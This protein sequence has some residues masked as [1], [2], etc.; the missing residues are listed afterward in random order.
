MEHNVIKCPNCGELITIDATSYNSVVKQIRDAEFER[1]LSERSS[2]IERTKEQEK[3]IL[4]QQLEGK[5]QHDLNELSRKY[6]RQISDNTIAAD[7]RYQEL[8]TNF[9]QKILSLQSENDKNIN[10]ITAEN[11]QNIS[12]KDI[13]VANLKNNIDLI[14]KENEL[15]T[16][17]LRNDFEHALKL[18]DDELAQYKD[19]RMKQ[20]TKMIGE[21]LEVFCR[22]S[23]NQYRATQWPSAYF[24]KD[25]DI[26]TGSKGDFILRDFAE[27]IE[28]LSV[29]IECKNEMSTTATKHKN[30]D[31]FKELDKDR[32]E[33]NCRW[34]LMV[35]TLE[36]DNELYNTGVAY[37]CYEYPDMYVV[38]PQNFIAMLE[39]LRGACIGNVESLK[40]AKMA[41]EKNCDIFAFEKEFQNYIGDIKQ[42]M[43]WE[44]NNIDEAIRNIESM[45]KTLEAAKE[46]LYRAKKRSKA[47]VNKVET[48]TMDKL[49]KNSPELA[50]NYKK[51][52]GGGENDEENK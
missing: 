11:M 48:V 33:K 49:L 4:K 23:F 6:E 43:T 22:N 50:A 16:E 39:I 46:A 18:K 41:E 3:I 24:E 30:S 40:R 13:E 8:R 28:Y 27:G 17:K 35:S 15:K 47:I 45:E 29:M 37:R 32:R 2:M 21:S 14:K 9:N 34:A 38:R 52:S 5:C 25:N 1:E 51:G 7:K 44:D 20:S 26:R 31:F 12:R 36:A 42:S 19:F 10:R